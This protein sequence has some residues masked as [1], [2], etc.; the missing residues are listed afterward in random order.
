M[1][2]NKLP[3]EECNSLSLNSEKVFVAGYDHGKIVGSNVLQSVETY[4]SDI[5]TDIDFALIDCSLP[6]ESVLN[7]IDCLL[8]HCGNES[9]LILKNIYHDKACDAI[10]RRLKADNKWKVCADFF[11]FGVFFM[12]SRPLQRQEYLLCKR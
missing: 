7:Y 4:C 8:P 6:K 1:A 9:V 2:H 10:F 5:S 3:A 12:T 11:S